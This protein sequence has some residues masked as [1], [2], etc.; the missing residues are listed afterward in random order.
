MKTFF[1]T[2][3][4]VSLF[5]I[6]NGQIFFV[7]EFNNNCASYCLAGLYA[8]PSGPWTLTDIGVN[9]PTPNEWFVSCAENG[10]PV[11]GCGTGCI[12][13]GDA[14]LHI[15]STIDQVFAGI[16]CPTGDCGAAYYAGFPPLDDVTTNKRIESPII[17]CSGALCAPTISFKYIFN[18]EPPF[19]YF[20]LEYFDGIAWS[21]I[22]NPAQTPLCPNGQGQWTLYSLPLP[23]S[24]IANANVQIGFRWINNNDGSG[25]DPSVAIDSVVVSAPAPLAPQFTLGDNTICLGASTTVTLTNPLPGVTYN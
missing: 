17:D 11:G 14:T 24:A 15:A 4:L 21:I 16:I 9:A 13:L 1:I 22:D 19:D 18:G 3:L 23:A 2:S 8:G 10:V 5:S 7:D 20:M 12:G 6:A 25:A